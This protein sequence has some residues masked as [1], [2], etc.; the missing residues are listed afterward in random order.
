MPDIVVWTVTVV[1]GPVAY[2]FVAIAIFETWKPAGELM[3]LALF[4]PELW[5]PLAKLRADEDGQKFKEAFRK[6]VRSEVKWLG[7]R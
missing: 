4:V 3:L 6:I 5:M 1:V 7:K 2:I